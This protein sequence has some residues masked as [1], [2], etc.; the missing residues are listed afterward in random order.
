MQRIGLLVLIGV[1]FL[2]YVSLA[3][4]TVAPLLVDRTLEPRSNEEVT[5]TLQNPSDRQVRVYATINRVAVDDSGTITEFRERGESDNRTTVTSWLAVNRGRIELAPGETREIPLTLDVHPQAEPG[6]YHAF[7]GFASGSNR[8]KAEAKVAAGEAPGSLVRIAVEA[9]RTA[10]LQLQQFFTERFL[11]KPADASLTYTISNPSDTPLRPSGEIIIYD[12]RGSE[13][14]AVNLVI[15]Q[16]LDPGE[17]Q[18]YRVSMPDLGN[19]IGKHKAMLSVRY[20]EGQTALLQDTVFFY[21]VPLVK[22]I[23]IFASILLFALLLAYWIHSRYR[24]D[25]EEDDQVAL[26]HRPQV[27]REAKDHDL[28]L[29]TTRNHDPDA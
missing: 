10:Y 24:T 9:D 17:E 15:P 5:I 12:S 6:V 4:H 27:V 28:D 14:G 25:P 29:K 23:A 13:L 26:Y 8:P 11:T 16:P 7:V 1:L 21:Q 2:P 18:E 20:G 3:Q 19:D 22:L